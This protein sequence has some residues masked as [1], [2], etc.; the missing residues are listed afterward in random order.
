M[1]VF[2]LNDLLIILVVDSE[3]GDRVLH[4]LGHLKAVIDLVLIVSLLHQNK[5]C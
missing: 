3:E 4:G 5:R 1:A 2:L